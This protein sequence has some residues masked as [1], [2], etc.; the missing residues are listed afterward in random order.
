MCQMGLR[1]G[2]LI[3]LASLLLITGCAGTSTHQSPVSGILPVISPSPIVQATAVPLATF[4]TVPTM[5]P[6]SPPTYTPQPTPSE[7]TPT[8]LDLETPIPLQT[9]SPLPD[10]ST[11]RWRTLPISGQHVRELA[12]LEYPAFPLSLSADGRWLDMVLAY[13]LSTGNSAD[14]V[15]D[16]E[17]NNH[18][19][20]SIQ[21]WFYPDAYFTPHYYPPSPWLPDERALWTKDGQVFM[22]NGQNQRVLDPPEPMVNIQYASRDI[23]FASSRAGYLWRVD[24]RSDKWEQVNA[25]RPPRAGQLSGVILAWDGSYGV[26]ISPPDAWRI[27]TRMGAMA[28]PLPDVKVNVVGRGGTTAA[29]A[30]LVNSPYWL[31]GLPIENNGGAE[32]FVVDLRNG[33]VLNSSDIGLP[34]KYALIDYS[35]SPGGHWLAITLWQ[36]ETQ[37]TGPNDSN[38]ELYLAPSQN[39]KAGHVLKGVSVVAWHTDPPAVILRDNA[40]GMLQVMRLP[41]SSTSS[42]VSLP[43]AKPPVTTLPNM[44]FA[45]ADDSPARLLQFDL[46]GHLIGTLDLSAYAEGIHTVMGRGD[47]V[48]LDV[49]GS[50]LQEM[51]YSHIN[52]RICTYSL[53][54]WIVGQ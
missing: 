6:T 43:G 3:V 35:I 20:L 52:V 22:G 33:H 24:L 15:I 2:F 31:I 8:E 18:R 38:L 39:L 30:E 23:A 47:R 16:T 14:V 28:E 51:P 45:V 41:I 9:P 42:V 54:E 17:G 7:C 46:D 49:T 1:S 48:F 26:A 21:H 50:R 10:L 12:G 32:G 53:I 5:F 4:T 37:Y 11:L 27:P 34:E 13:G 25:P 29:T 36:T 40:T 19:W 44:I